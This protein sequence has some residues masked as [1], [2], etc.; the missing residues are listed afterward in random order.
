MV[1]WLFA[2]ALGRVQ[3]LTQTNDYDT[4]PPISTKGY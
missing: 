3:T 4:F 1:Y 2:T